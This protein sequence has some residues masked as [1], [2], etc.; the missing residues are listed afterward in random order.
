M[1]LTEDTPFHRLLA[2]KH[3]PNREQEALG[4]L[5]EHPE[6]ALLEWPGSDLQSDPFLP[7]STALHYAANDGR[8]HL[9]RRLVELGADTNASNTRRWYRSVLS[10]AANN[11]R[12]ETITFLLQNGARPDSLDALHAAA[13][14]GPNRGEGREHEYVAA[15]DMLITAGANLNDRRHFKHCT[16]LAVA[17]ESGNAGAIHFLRSLG[18]AEI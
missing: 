1:A 13:W 15:L 18:A 17:I 16:P 10:W 14:G 2:T 7:G 12:L 3:D 4:I 11:A 9:V 8:L 5:Q 6:I